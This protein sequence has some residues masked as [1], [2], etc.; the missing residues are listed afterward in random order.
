MMLHLPQLLT[1]DEVRTAQALLGD[2]ATWIDGRTSAGAALPVP[3]R[4]TATPWCRSP[5]APDQSIA[6]KCLKRPFTVSPRE[7][8]DLVPSNACSPEAPACAGV[9]ALFFS[10]RFL[11]Q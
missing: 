9:H 2:D 3:H 6:A 8:G 5:A 11:S 10:R 7:G 1:S 4:A